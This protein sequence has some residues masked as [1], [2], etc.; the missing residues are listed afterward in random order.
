MGKAEEALQKL[1]M[2]ARD[3]CRCA[4]KARVSRFPISA[5][6]YIEIDDVDGERI[7]VELYCK[8]FPDEIDGFP[9]RLSEALK[10]RL[11]DDLPP[12]QGMEN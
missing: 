12:V 10:N 2:L 5:E 6:E 8:I 1:V 9:V 11:E 4:I 7:F 3:S